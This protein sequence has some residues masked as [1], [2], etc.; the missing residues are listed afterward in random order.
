LKKGERTC[1]EPSAALTGKP[2]V[3]EYVDKLAGGVF[4]SGKF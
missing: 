2:V 1:N 4:S 3:A